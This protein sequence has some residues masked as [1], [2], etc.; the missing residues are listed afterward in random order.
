MG[1]AIQRI[2]SL[3][4]VS[5]GLLSGLEDGKLINEGGGWTPGIVPEC[6][7]VLE[8]T[9]GSVINIQLPHDRPDLWDKVSCLANWMT[10][11]A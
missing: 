8:A 4:P 7:G 10:G 1:R 9:A 5:E 6:A 2:R 3:L 11:S